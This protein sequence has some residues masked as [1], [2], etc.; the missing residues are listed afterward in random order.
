M[1]PLHTK[2]SFHVTYLVDANV[3][4]MPKRRHDLQSG[5]GVHEL[6]N[7]IKHKKLMIDLC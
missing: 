3:S 1:L 6:S 5:K 4:F 2:C 7:V